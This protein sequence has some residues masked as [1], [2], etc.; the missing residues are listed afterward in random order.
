[1]KG[2]PLGLH[3]DF[4]LLSTYALLRVLVLFAPFRCWRRSGRWIED[5]TFTCRMQRVFVGG[6]EG[7]WR[8]YS[9]LNKFAPGSFFFIILVIACFVK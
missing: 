1:M 2:M 5:H 8:I 4:A 6:R 9:C 3:R 7:Q